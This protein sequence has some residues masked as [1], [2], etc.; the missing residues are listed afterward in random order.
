IVA[1]AELLECLAAPQMAEV[2]VGR[3]LERELELCE[4]V[5]VAARV[6]VDPSECAVGDERKRVR[7]A[8]AA[9]L[10]RRLVEATHGDEVVRIPLMCDGVAGIELDRLPELRLRAG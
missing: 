1:P 3:H 2:P 5:L 9:H 4:R 7:L 10:A 8:R 6:E